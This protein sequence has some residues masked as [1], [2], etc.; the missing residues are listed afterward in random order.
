[1][2]LNA[3]NAT[4]WMTRA[5]IVVAVRCAESSASSSRSR[6]S[7]EPAL[8]RN[9]IS[10]PATIIVVLWNVA[11]RSTAAA[12]ETTGTIHAVLTTGVPSSWLSCDRDALR[13][14][15]RAPAPAATAARTATLQK[16]ALVVCARGSGFFFSSRR[17]H[18]R[19][20]CDW[21]SDVCSSDLLGAQGDADHV[22]Q[23]VDPG[24][25]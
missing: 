9:A 25:Q 6:E 8:P 3:R 16:S 1:M 7:R 19:S 24:L 10:G 11:T 12:V 14:A 21:S 23:L 13:S 2:A 4:E 15:K 5:W 18:T 22:G 20:L 17:R